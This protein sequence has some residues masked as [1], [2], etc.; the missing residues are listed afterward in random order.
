MEPERFT[1]KSIT[2]KKLSKID[3]NLVY[4]YQID[5]KLRVVLSLED[6]EETRA[7]WNHH[8]E[9]EYEII[10]GTKSLE[11]NLIV[12]NTGCNQI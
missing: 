3:F 11:T 1:Q 5:E 10:L 8:F 12:K 4:K 6:D 2:L 9:L 7:I